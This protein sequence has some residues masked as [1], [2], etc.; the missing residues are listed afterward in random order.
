MYIILFDDWLLKLDSYLEH[1][2]EQIQTIS[3]LLNSTVNYLV[4][5]MNA[6]KRHRLCLNLQANHLNSTFL[7]KKCAKSMQSIILNRNHHA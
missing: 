5:L 1:E 7:P 6:L 3:Y 4:L 2:I